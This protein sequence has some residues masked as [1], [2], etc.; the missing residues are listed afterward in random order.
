MRYL[1]T[2]ETPW[3]TSC[4]FLFL[5]KET[6]TNLLAWL[7]YTYQQICF[8]HWM[9]HSSSRRHFA[10]HWRIACDVMVA[11]LLDRS[12]KIFLHWELTAIFMQTMWANFLLFYPLT[13]RQCSPHTVAA[14]VGISNALSDIWLNW[15]VIT[16]WIPILGQSN[17]TLVLKTTHAIP[18]IPVKL[19]TLPKERNSS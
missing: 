16:V 7:S 14:Q 12:N 18:P 11:M 5:M 1:K 15:P 4:F 13:W 19:K 17:A 2:F 9:Y 8:V 10:W 3:N 6:H